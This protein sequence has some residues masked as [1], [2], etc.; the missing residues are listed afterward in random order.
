[1]SER[2]F[3]GRK[4][5]RRPIMS[6]HRESGLYRKNADGTLTPVAENGSAEE[7]V[8]AFADGGEFEEAEEVGERLSRASREHLRSKEGHL[9]TKWDFLMAIAKQFGFNAVL[10]IIMIGVCVFLYRENNKTRDAF[11]SALEKNTGALT[12]VAKQQSATSEAVRQTNGRLDKLTDL[13]ASH[14]D[15][16][17]VGAGTHHRPH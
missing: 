3:G 10:V 12:E 2:K 6:K 1:M 4:P 14:L 9:E 17:D 5:E 15:Q 11:L 8:N 13:M 16:E 7:E